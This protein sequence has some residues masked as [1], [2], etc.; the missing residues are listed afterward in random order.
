MEEELTQIKQEKNT[1]QNFHSEEIK[2]KINEL[3]ASYDIK[4]KELSAKVDQYKEKNNLRK[5][6]VKLNSNN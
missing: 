4:V 1:N 6:K 2:T 5:E 3:R